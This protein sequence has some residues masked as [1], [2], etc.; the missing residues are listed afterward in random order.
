MPQGGFSRDFHSAAMLKAA[1]QKERDK[2]ERQKIGNE[3]IGEISQRLDDEVSRIEK[4]VIQK[5]E[6]SFIILADSIKARDRML[7]FLAWSLFASL[8]ANS[9][10]LGYFL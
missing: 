3:V 8:V 10:M 7:R 1:A 2:Q 4:D 5:N 6:E 9:F